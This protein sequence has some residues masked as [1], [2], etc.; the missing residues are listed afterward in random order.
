VA[1][2]GGAQFALPGAVDRLRAAREPDPDDQALV[3]LAATDPAQ[4]FGAALP[5][6]ESSGRPARAAGALV[7]LAG[8]EPVAYL[9]RGGRSLLV[10]PAAAHHPAWATAVAGV[11]GRGRSRRLEVARIDGDPAAES[12]HAEAL[13]AAGFRDGYRGLTLGGR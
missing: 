6:P 12:P 13:R 9:E 7:V 11:V 4:P 1:G 2:L 8:G 5:W 10:F 3:V